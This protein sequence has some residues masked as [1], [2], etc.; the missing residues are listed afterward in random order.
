MKRL[1]ISKDCFSENLIKRKCQRYL[2]E[3]HN[4]VKTHKS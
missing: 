3:K 2:K 1:S 4:S